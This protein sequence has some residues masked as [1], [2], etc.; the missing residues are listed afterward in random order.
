MKVGTL[1]PGANVNRSEE[2]RRMGVM[3]PLGLRC[4]IREMGS[5]VG[6]SGEDGGEMLY[7][8]HWLLVV[9]QCSSGHNGLNLAQILMSHWRTVCH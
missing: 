5:D 3:Y 9:E 7:R 8:L 6:A 2:P 4:W 1:T